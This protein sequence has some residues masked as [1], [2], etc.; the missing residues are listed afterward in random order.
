MKTITTELQTHLQSEVTTLAYCWKLAFA[1]SDILGFTSHDNDIV[2]E[3]VTYKSR[4]GFTLDQY[5]NDLTSNKDLSEIFG[6]IDSDLLTETD[7][8]SGRLDNATLEIFLVNYQS[9][10]DG[11]ILLKKG[12]VTEIKQSGDE[13]IIGISGLIDELNRNITEIYSPLCRARLGDSRCGVDL[14]SFTSSGSVTA[15]TNERIFE[16]SAREEENG[17]FDKGVITFTSGSNTGFSTEVK[18]S[19]GAKITLSIPFPNQISVNDEY[20][21][22]AGCDKKFSTCISKF[23]NAVNFR[24]EPHIPGVNEIFKVL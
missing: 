12:K 11:R 21:I 2:F 24:G 8:R 13:Y 5:K 22:K 14:I 9:P 1:D 10:A 18:R 20:T 15:V 4:S 16:D 7:I 3:S 6:I 23:N 19:E 17:Y